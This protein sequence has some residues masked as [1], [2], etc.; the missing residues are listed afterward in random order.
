MIVAE[1]DEL[2]KQMALT[3]ALEKALAFL[4]EHRSAAGLAERVE[5][6][7][8]AVYALV[9]DFETEPVGAEVDFEAHRL[10]LDI[11][12]VVVGEELMGWAPL[13]ELRGAG[14]YNPAKDV[15]HGLFPAAEMTPVRVKAG[16]AAV[17]FPQD[18]HAPK[19]AAG[20]PGWVKKIVVKVAVQ[21]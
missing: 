7:G 20:K 8:T 11:Q 16:Q 18:A 21:S 13:S 6:D 4:S 14:A 15:L 5:I 2:A 19:L 9:Q 12:Y 3:P 1:L 10:Y 17:F